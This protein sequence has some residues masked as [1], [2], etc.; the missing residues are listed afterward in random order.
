M[1]AVHTPPKKRP[2][3]AKATSKARK[4]AAPKYIARK[5]A[6][7][8]MAI[9]PARLL[10]WLNL[11]QGDCVTA[12]E[13]WA[14]AV[15]SIMAGQTELVIT[16]ATVQ[17]WASGNGVLN[18]AELGQVLDLMAAAGFSQGGQVYGD[19]P[20]A[21]VDYTNV[22]ALQAAI[23]EGPVKL[24]VVGDPLENVVGTKN[25]WLLQGVPKQSPDDEDHCIGLS[26]Y[27][28]LA[29]LAA[30]YNVTL[31]STANPANLGWAAFTWGTMGILDNASLQN[32][33]FEAWLRT[34]TTVLQG[35]PTP[36]APTPAPSGLGITVPTA[37]PAG[38]YQ[39]LAVGTAPVTVTM[40]PVAAALMQALLDEMERLQ[41]SK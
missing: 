1:S 25:G 39:L 21:M 2:R 23:S 9:I 40:S 3:G 27:G 20:A 4:D 38:T 37:I 31:P 8:W 30:T 13:A 7:P 19:G 32:M 6:A 34:P 5:R 18:G 36:P 14:K 24:G 16:D 41:P 22:A 29:Q 28:T 15:A 11:T 10:D 35:G 26:G 33:C 17:T 12:E